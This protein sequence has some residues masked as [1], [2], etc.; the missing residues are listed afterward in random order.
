MFFSPSAFL[1]PVHFG[2]M[3]TLA[4]SVCPVS[5]ASFTCPVFVYFSCHLSVFPVLHFRNSLQVLQLLF[6]A[7]SVCPCL[8]ASFTLSG[9]CLLQLPSISFSGISFRNSLQVL[10]MYINIFLLPCIVL[11]VLHL[12]FAGE[13]RTRDLRIMS[14]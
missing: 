11:I 10:Q 14:R 4:L 7:L 3:C 12:C 5:L 8:S 9:I 6:L 1:F 13:I 2:F